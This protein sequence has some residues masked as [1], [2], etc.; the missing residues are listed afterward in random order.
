[1]ADNVHANIEDLRK[2]RREVDNAQRSINDALKKLSSTLN[3][4]DWKDRARQDFDTR[5]QAAQGSV[6]SVTSKLDELKPILDRK[7]RD[8]ETYL[9]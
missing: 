1:M 3:G 2:L 5:L 8:L 6:R 4:A 9:R 7:V